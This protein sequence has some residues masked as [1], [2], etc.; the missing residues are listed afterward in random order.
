MIW[1]STQGSIFDMNP[2]LNKLEHKRVWVRE[3]NSYYQIINRHHM[4]KKKKKL[5]ISFIDYE[6]VY[7]GLNRN[8]LYERLT[9]HS[10][11]KH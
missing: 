3:A 9:K 7:D 1:Y 10:F 8:K 4:K 6:K 11:S 2:K 5:Y